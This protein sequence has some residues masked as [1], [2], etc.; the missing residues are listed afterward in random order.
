MT[1]DKNEVLKMQKAFITRNKNI[2]YN[3]AS[4][5]ILRLI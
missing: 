4:I 3:N 1:L 2:K 5:K